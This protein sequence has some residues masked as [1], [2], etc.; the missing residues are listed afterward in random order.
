[1]LKACLGTLKK[2]EKMA[3]KIDVAKDNKISTMFTVDSTYNSKNLGLI[4]CG[5]VVRG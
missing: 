4:L 2:P 3:E 1:L 5:S